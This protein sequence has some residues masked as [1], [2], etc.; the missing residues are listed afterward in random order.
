MGGCCQGLHSTRIAD[1]GINGTTF[2]REV[3]SPI[4]E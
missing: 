3:Q 2:R 1:L 4:N